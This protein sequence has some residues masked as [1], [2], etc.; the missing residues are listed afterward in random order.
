VTDEEIERLADEAERGYNP[1]QLRPRFHPDNAKLHIARIQKLAQE[2]QAEA[3][4]PR[5]W[6]IQWADELECVRNLPLGPMR[7]VYMR[8]WTIETPWFSIRLHHWLHSDDQRHLHDHPWGFHTFVL[9]GAY[10][11]TSS[12]EGADI[13]EEREDWQFQ[14]M[15]AGTY[16]YRPS[17]HKH[18]VKVIPP[19]CWTLVFTGP[20]MRRWGFWV[21]GK[22]K[23][24]N[25]YFLEHGKHACD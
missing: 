4:P 8:R 13:G 22:F 23:R 19:G 5:H 14:L 25:K 2:R 24:V 15:R 20:I 3:K 9:K 11:D 16:A 12:P 18:Y 1:A 17:H 21:K 10:I 6:R 7:G